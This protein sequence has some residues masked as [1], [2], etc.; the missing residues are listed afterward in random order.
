MTDACRLPLSH[1][2]RGG[3]RRCNAVPGEIPLLPLFQ[4]LVTASAARSDTSRRS[5]DTSAKLSN[6]SFMYAACLYVQRV[7]V[8]ADIAGHGYG[9]DGP[10][11]SFVVCGVVAMVVRD[12]PRLLGGRYAVG[13]ELGSGG[14]AVVLEAVDLLLDRRVA[15]KIPLP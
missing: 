9:V 7:T 6:W 2:G 4:L 15:V 11:C 8:L 10:L 1:P 5:H 12:V 3:P 14:T 13:R